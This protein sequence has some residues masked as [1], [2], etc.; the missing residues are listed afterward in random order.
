MELYKLTTPKD[1]AW[2]V[3]EKLGQEDLV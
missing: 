3:I 2:K 1:E